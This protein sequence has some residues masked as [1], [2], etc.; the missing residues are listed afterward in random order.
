MKNPFPI[1]AAGALLLGTGLWNCGCSRSESTPAPGASP[2]PEAAPFPRPA[3]GEFS[4]MTFNLNQYALIDRDGTAET[5]EPK[6]PEEAAAIIDVIRQ[7]S[8]DILAVQ[9]MGDPAAWAEFKFSLRQAGLEYGNEEYLRRG[10]H[11]LNIAVLSRFP[12]VQNRSHTDDTYTIG[13]AQFPV[14]RG[15]A[16]VDIQVN[17]AYRFRLMVAHLKSKVFHSFGQAEMR[18]NEARLL[19]NH[20]RDSLKENPDINL[21]VVG[22]FNDDPSSAPLREIHS[23]K[24][25]LLLHD[26]RPAD[27]V[28]DA[29]THREND[30]MY[31]RIDY[32]LASDGMLPETITSKTYAV[33]SPLLLRASDHR[34]IVA[35]FVAAE[36][37]PEAAPDLSKSLPPEVP[38]ND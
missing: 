32:M 36:R 3:E 10:K 7:V 1:A 25:A 31:H 37:G 20:V 24:R 23:Y 22:D 2:A 29:W 15:I 34:P 38:Q 5:L 4:V 19:G 9:E 8:P 12:I 26:L 28:G 21:L 6:P 35:T 13:P 27:P 16:E 30:D 11:E 17:P 14:M 18:R 33:R